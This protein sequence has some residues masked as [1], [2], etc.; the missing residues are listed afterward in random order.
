MDALHMSDVHLHRGDATVLQGIQ[1]RV[2]KGQVV[3][4]QGKSGSGKTSIL[5]CAAGL[6]QPSRGTIQVAGHDMSERPAVTR[7]DHIGL[8]FQNLR[9]LPELTL[10]DNVELGLRLAGVKRTPR[11]ERALQW[12]RTFGIEHLAQR[13]PHQA[14]GGE[15]QRA[16]IARAMVMEPSLLLV[17]EPTSALDPE[18]SATVVQALHTAAR[19]GVGVLVATHD[20]HVRGDHLHRVERGQIT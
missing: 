14:S 19:G 7:R 9:L 1:L 8:V 12:M 4:L 18:T 20:P 6:L 17:D 3:V 10:Q 16:A 2:P 5:S 15:Q 13:Q 11:G